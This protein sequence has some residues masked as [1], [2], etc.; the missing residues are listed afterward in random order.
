MSEIFILIIVAGF[1]TTGPGAISINQEFFSQKNCEEA[2][3]S[4]VNQM[5]GAATIRVQSYYKK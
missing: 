2:R 1:N 4:I 5:Y 3:V